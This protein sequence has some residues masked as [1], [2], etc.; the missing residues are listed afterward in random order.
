M[1]DKEYKEIQRDLYMKLK[2]FDTTVK[3]ATES[4]EYKDA[5]AY[6]QGIRDCIDLLKTKVT[7]TNETESSVL[8]K[9]VWSK[10]DIITYLERLNSQVNNLFPKDEEFREDVINRCRNDKQFS[11]ILIRAGEP[12]IIRHAM[13][14][15]ATRENK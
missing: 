15:L 4:P 10:Q 9:T 3:G 8:G 7:K 12:T 6:N 14:A 11:D 1:T 5:Q 13:D 2:M